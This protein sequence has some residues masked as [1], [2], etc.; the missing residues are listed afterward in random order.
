MTTRPRLT[1][2]DIDALFAARGGEQYTGE[3]VTQLA[4]ALQTAQL[5]EDDGGSDELVTACLLH[6]LGHLVADHG[7]T[8]TLHGIDDEHQHVALPLLKPLFDKAVLGAIGLHVD[9][10]RYLCRVDAGYHAALSDDS[11]RSLVLQGGTFDDAQA[12]AFIARPGAEDA[13]RLR[14]YDDLAKVAGRAT[15]PLAHF[16]ARAGR[17]ARHDAQAAA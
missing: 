16:L 6:D 3:P 8:P 12:A 9:A 2:A 14:R 1:L 4:H 11:K 5:A 17:I 13:V 15:Q 7:E 10:K